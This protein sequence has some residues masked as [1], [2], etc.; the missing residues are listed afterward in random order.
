MSTTPIWVQL[1]ALPMEYWGE[2]CIRKIAGQLGNVLKIDN[3]TM[4]KD[5]LMYARA[6][7][8][9]DIRKGL[10]DEVLFTNEYDEQVKQVVQ[11]DWKPL[12]CHQCQQQG[13]QS[14]ACK[15]KKTLN[16]IHK[17]PPRRDWVKKRSQIDRTKPQ[18]I[19]QDTSETRATMAIQPPEENT[20]L[21]I[22]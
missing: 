21:E 5:R 3:A 17:K 4:N 8:E 11:Y 7:V 10:P 13:H 14:G 20:Q 18:T 22:L 9:L 12:W 1:P 19:H 16:P 6:L 2:R 15:P